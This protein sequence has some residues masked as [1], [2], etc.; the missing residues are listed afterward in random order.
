MPT[1]SQPGR[2]GAVRTQTIPPRRHRRDLIERPIVRARAA[3]RGRRRGSIRSERRHFGARQTLQ[4]RQRR[5]TARG[6]RSPSRR[7]TSSCAGVD[8]APIDAGERPHDRQRHHRAQSRTPRRS[9]PRTRRGPRNQ[10]RA[11]R[12]AQAHPRGAE[13]HEPDR[14]VPIEERFAVRAT[15][16]ACPSAR[17]VALFSHSSHTRIGLAD[18]ERESPAVD[19]H[20]RA[21]DEHRHGQRGQ[22]RR[23][24]RAMTDRGPA[25]AGRDRRAAAASARRTA[26]ARCVPPHHIAKCVTASR[27][28]TARTAAR[29]RAAAVARSRDHHREPD[30]RDDRAPARTRAGR[31]ADR[32]TVRPGRPGM[33]E[34][35]P[36]SFAY[37]ADGSGVP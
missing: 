20:E 32:R 12:R 2:A 25:D 28:G 7:R 10:R 3:R 23:A 11:L 26:P 18:V 15:T 33:N 31:S 36:S 27:Y 8:V 22:H 30:E 37:G 4:S 35:E 29:G 17:S 13:H 19:E 6:A 5:A 21:R 14:D 16:R 24:R 1:I 34:A 9:L